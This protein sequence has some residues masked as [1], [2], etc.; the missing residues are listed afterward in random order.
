MTIIVNCQSDTD[1]KLVLVS[2]HVDAP[3]ITF[4]IKIHLYD[5]MEIDSAVCVSFDQMVDI[6]NTADL[7][8]VYLSGIGQRNNNLKYIESLYSN[9]D[10]S[11][12]YYEKIFQK[13]KIKIDKH[14][15]LIS[16]K[17]KK[18]DLL[19][20]KYESLKEEKNKLHNEK[21]VTDY[22]YN[23]EKKNKIIWG[24]VALLAVIANF[25]H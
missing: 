25:L 6:N 2:Y 20:V 19:Y 9:A 7:R 23:I 13:Q 1:G 22:K 12:S 14:D 24:C 3:E 4:P 15:E 18:Y 8:D 21:E 16:K 11:I 5:N 17:N 10:K